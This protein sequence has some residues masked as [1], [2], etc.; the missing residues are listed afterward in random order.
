MLLHEKITPSFAILD[1]IVMHSS[2]YIPMK[3]IAF[4]NFFT[5]ILLPV[6]A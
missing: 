2:W 4:F 1:F 3:D 5:F 6:G